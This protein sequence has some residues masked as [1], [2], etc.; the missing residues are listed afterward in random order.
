LPIPRLARNKH[1]AALAGLGLLPTALQQRQ[2]LV[3]ADERRA[4]R[5]QCLEAAL[6]PTLAQ[7]PRGRDRRCQ[8]LDL[9]RPEIGIVE[10]PDGQP[11]GARRDHHCSRFGQRLQP[12]RQVRRLADHRLLSRRACAEQIADDDQSGGDPDPC[13]QLRPRRVVKAGHRLDRC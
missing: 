9:N 13:R 7:Y 3:A 2:L 6:G 4:G 8:A 10:Q 11:T 1:D 5:A 12:R